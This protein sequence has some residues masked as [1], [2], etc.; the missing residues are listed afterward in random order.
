MSGKIRNKR[1]SSA[2]IRKQ[3][4][5]LEVTVRADKARAM[6]NRAVASFICKTIFFTGLA[7]GAWFGGKELLRRFLWENPDYLL[8]EI[9]VPLDGAL[10]KEQIL[11][12]TNL[13]E[14]VNIFTVDIKRARLALDTLPQVERAEIQRILPNRIDINIIERRPIAWVTEK[15]EENPTGSDRSWLIDARGV[16]MKTK[17]MLEEYYHL[18]HISGVPVANF[19]PGQRITTVEMQSALELIRLNADNTRWQA[20]NIDLA[21]GL[22]PDRHRPEPRP[23]HLRSRRYEST[24]GS[25]LP[26]SRSCRCREE[27][28]SDRESPGEEEHPG[29]LS[30]L[31]RG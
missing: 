14:G 19:V 17:R 13:H 27:G 12:A 9:R 15:A 28:D 5:L 11:D 3:Q 4:H 20:R 31:R 29:H 7:V 26:L 21:K 18:A 6:R 25:A 24:T 10:Q 8:T 23:H 2:K 30:S 22:L 16:V 1:I